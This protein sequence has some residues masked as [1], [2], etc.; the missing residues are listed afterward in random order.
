[1]TLEDVHDQRR[2][3]L[4]RLTSPYS[5]ERILKCN[6]IFSFIVAAYDEESA[7]RMYPYPKDDLDITFEIEGD[8]KFWSVKKR[9]NESYSGFILDHDPKFDT[10]EN[11]WKYEDPKY[12]CLQYDYF[13]V[14]GDDV[15][16]I[17]IDFYDII[18]K[19]NMKEG[20]IYN[21]LKISPYLQFRKF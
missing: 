7:R 16:D 6:Y 20:E 9:N 13:W 2:L 14:E 1:M 11:I 15:D 3:K 10:P 21:I 12:I 4:Y 19:N 18:R 5:A 17:S 8:L